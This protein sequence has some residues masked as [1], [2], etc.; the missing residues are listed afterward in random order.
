M[1][2]IIQPKIIFI[3][4]PYYDQIGIWPLSEEEL[5]VGAEYF[6]D[7]IHFFGGLHDDRVDPDNIH[8]SEI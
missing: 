3:Y 8:M 7:I 2:T 5:W 4:N 6:T 1:T